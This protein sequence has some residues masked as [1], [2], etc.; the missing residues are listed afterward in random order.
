MKLL[1]DDFKSEIFSEVTYVLNRILRVSSRKWPELKLLYR[2]MRTTR[3]FK[4]NITLNSLFKEFSYQTS[5]CT[6]P[7]EFLLEALFPCLRF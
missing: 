3:V 1:D 5:L 2:L 4:S 7:F 6:G